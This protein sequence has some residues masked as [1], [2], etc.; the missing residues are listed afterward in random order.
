[1]PNPNGYYID[2][3]DRIIVTAEPETVYLPTPSGSHQEVEVWP[4]Q[5]FLRCEGL[6]R[7]LGYKGR[8]SVVH[9]CQDQAEWAQHVDQRDASSRLISD[10]DLHGLMQ[11][12]KKDMSH[13]PSTLTAEMAVDQYSEDPE[14][15]KRRK[16][17]RRTRGTKRRNQTETRSSS[18]D[19]AGELQQAKDDAVYYQ[20]R[21]EEAERKLALARDLISQYRALI[22]DQIA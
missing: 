7:A 3:K 12:A 10:E 2:G 9:H 19:K 11:G 4:D 6:H 5:G 8:D 18:G 1:M 13:L 14:V 20:Q 22:D 21:A 15:K 16:S 17:Y